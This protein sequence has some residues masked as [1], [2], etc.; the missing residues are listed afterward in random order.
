M[1]AKTTILAALLAVAPM[2][3]A[4]QS[5]AYSGESVAELA[6]DSG[7]S[8]RNVRMILGARTPYAEYRCCYNRMV[9]QF[10]QAVGEE[11]YQRLAN[12]GYVPK[13]EAPVA[14]RAE[15]DKD[16]AARIEISAL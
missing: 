16:T 11:T 13:A 4:G 6:R 14:A 15:E 2:A 1:Y 12:G 8:E 3:Q 5:A 7:L 10:K 9:R